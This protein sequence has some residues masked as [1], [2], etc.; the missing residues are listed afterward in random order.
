MPTANRP[1]ARANARLLRE[2]SIIRDGPPPGHP[3]YF[4]SDAR[5]ARAFGVGRHVLATGKRAAS[6]ADPAEV[7]HK[8]IHGGTAFESD[9]DVQELREQRLMAGIRR[10]RRSL[11]ITIR[12]SE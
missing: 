8:I 9:F 2:V 3:V 1:G 10:G 11:P 4:R 7:R 12:P 6:R 5:W